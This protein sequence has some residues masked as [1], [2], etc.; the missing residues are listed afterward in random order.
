MCPWAQAIQKQSKSR[1]DDDGTVF[2]QNAPE[3]CQNDIPTQPAA[4]LAQNA[5]TH[6]WV[7][8]SGAV[9][10]APWKDLSTIYVYC[11]Q[12]QAIL[13]P[14]QQSFVQEAVDASG[15]APMATETNDSCH[16]PFL[17]RPDEVIGS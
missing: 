4:E 2:V 5:V 14:L 3:S 8:A 16:C 17:S 9:M 12:D 13:Q 15:S 10:S 6:N 7:T 11:A 1:P